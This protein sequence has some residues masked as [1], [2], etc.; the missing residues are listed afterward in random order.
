MW[1]SR[2]CARSSGTV[3]LKSSSCPSARVFA[4]R[5]FQTSPHGL[6]PCASLSL[7]L[8]QAVKTSKL[9]NVLGTHRKGAARWAAL[10][11]ASLR[12]RLEAHLQRQLHDAHRRVEPEEVSIRA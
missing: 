12:D 2:S 1:A 10:F 7:R 4:S 3:G 9:S 6:G 8:H 11:P 5:F